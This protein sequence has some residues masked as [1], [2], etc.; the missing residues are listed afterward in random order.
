MVAIKHA[1]NKFNYVKLIDFLTFKQLDELE[2]NE[3]LINVFDVEPMET[4]FYEAEIQNLNDVFDCHTIYLNNF[5]FEREEITQCENYYFQKLHNL[6]DYADDWEAKRRKINNI[7]FNAILN[8]NKYKYLYERLSKK[9][10]NTIRRETIELFD[11][12]KDKIQGTYLTKDIQRNLKRMIKSEYFEKI[13][14][15]KHNMEEILK[16]IDKSK[17]IIK[18]NNIKY[19]NIKSFVDSL[20]Q[21]EQQIIRK[22]QEYYDEKE[23]DINKRDF[24]TLI[25]NYLRDRNTNTDWANQDYLKDIL[26]NLKECIFEKYIYYDFNNFENHLYDK[27]KEYI[28]SDDLEG[29]EMYLNDFKAKTPKPKTYMFIINI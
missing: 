20:G 13:V 19:D 18:C 3:N 23:F 8:K 7:I 27:F 10:R 25:N 26:N 4:R 15:K 2:Q 5:D 28:E 6:A 24:Y 17:I 1:E 16:E 21:R 29:F 9:E 14:Y 22:R 11:Y 12:M